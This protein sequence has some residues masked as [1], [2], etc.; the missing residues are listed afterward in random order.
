MF[1]IYVLSP[2]NTLQ[3]ETHLMVHSTGCLRFHQSYVRVIRHSAHLAL[4][5]SKQDELRADPSSCKRRSSTSSATQE[6]GPPNL[7]D[8]VTGAIRLCH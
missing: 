8:Y 2:K 7:E 1:P 4:L 6:M 3:R 5:S